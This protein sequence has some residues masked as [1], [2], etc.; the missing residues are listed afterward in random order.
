[1]QCDLQKQR[2]CVQIAIHFMQEKFEQNH[3]PSRYRCE[4]NPQFPISPICLKKDRLLSSSISFTY[5]RI[6]GSL[7]L[8]GF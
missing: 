3:S 7:S 5:L 6:Q 8:P 2:M 4:V 1:M